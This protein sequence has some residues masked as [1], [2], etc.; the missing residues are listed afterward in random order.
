MPL[1]LEARIRGN[2]QYNW[3]VTGGFD[4]HEVQPPVRIISFIASTH[5]LLSLV[6]LGALTP[7]PRYVCQHTPGICRGCLT[8]HGW[9][10]APLARS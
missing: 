1:E 8:Q 6:P 2:M 9:T 4:F 7:K 10:R 3:S 5:H